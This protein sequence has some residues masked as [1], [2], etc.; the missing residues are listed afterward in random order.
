MNI[1]E[2][3][4]RVGLF[5]VSIFIGIIIYETIV[6]WGVANFIL[7]NMDGT[8]GDIIMLFFRVSVVFFSYVL[9]LMAFK[10]KITKPVKYI[11]WIAYLGTIFLLLFARKAQYSGINLN[12][13]RVARELQGRRSQIYFVGNILFFIP[14]GYLFR[15]LNFFIMF[16]VALCMEF[17]IEMMQHITRRGVFDIGDIIT[18]MTGILLGYIIVNLIIYIKKMMEKNKIINIE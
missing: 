1:K 15:K 17:T 16:F 7:I 10:L 8:R 4:I 12:L 18:N 11:L 5:I 6:K 3:F 14:F 2:F 13:H 9:L